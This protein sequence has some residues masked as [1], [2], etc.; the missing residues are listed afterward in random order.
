MMTNGGITLNSDMVWY[1]D[2]GASNHICRAKHLF[3]DIEE[4]EDGY[5]SF[6]D[7]TKFPVKGR[8]KI[9]FSQK[10]GKEGI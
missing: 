5:V 7:S 2:I 6:G 4:I 9:Y 1:L 8:G 10:H 3:T